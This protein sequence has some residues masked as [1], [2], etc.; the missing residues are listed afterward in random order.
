MERKRIKGR[1]VS[2]DSI[3]EVGTGTHWTDCSTLQR[4]RDTFYLGVGKEAE[5]EGRK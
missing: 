3:K 4:S 1:G 2:E 5:G